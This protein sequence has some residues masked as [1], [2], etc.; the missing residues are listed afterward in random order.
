MGAHSVTMIDSIPKKPKFADYDLVFVENRDRYFVNQVNQG[1]VLENNFANAA[2]LKQ[3]L[4]GL[5][6]TQSDVKADLRQI[7]G[8]AIGYELL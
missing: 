4:V 3:C 8:S 6:P 7:T 2:W 5:H 1:L